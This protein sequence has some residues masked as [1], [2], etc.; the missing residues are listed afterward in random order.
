MMQINLSATT[1]DIMLDSISML[2]SGT[3]N[4]VEDV[5]IVYLIL[6]SDSN[7]IYTPGKDGYLSYAYYLRDNGVILLDLDPD[8]EIGLIKETTL[9]ITYTMGDT[10]QVGETYSFDVI[11]MSSYPA[12]IDETVKYSGLPIKSAKKT[13]SVA[14]K[15]DVEV[16]N[17]TEN[18]TTTTTVQKQDQCET[19]D[20]CIGQ[21][22]QE[23]KMTTY[24]CSHDDSKGK[25]CKPVIANVDCCEDEDCP[26]NSLCVNQECTKEKGGLFDLFRSGGDDPGGERSINLVYIAAIVIVI[27]IVVVAFLYIRNKGKSSG[28]ASPPSPSSNP[29][30]GGSDWDEMRKRA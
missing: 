8:L 4:E 11:S 5:N 21:L 18:E 27:I 9:M 16:L 30:G 25:A 26:E 3:G 2:S 13:I 1:D 19:D 22:C 20:D 6:D 17:D 23:N 28:P 15:E 29:P 12:Y 10:G 24:V 14:A 7:G